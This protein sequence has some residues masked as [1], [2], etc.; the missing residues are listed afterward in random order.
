M[1]IIT[2]DGTAHDRQGRHACWSPAT[3]C[4][5]SPT[6]SATTR[7]ARRSASR[8]ATRIAD[9]GRRRPPSQRR[10]TRRAASRYSARARPRRRCSR[11][12]VE[13]RVVRHVGDDDARLA[14]QLLLDPERRLVVQ[15][16]V[17][18]VLGAYSGTI[19]VTTWSLVGPRDRA[20]VVEDRRDDLAV[21]R[22]D[23]GEP[24]A[25][26]RPRPTARVNSSALSPVTSTKTASIASARSVLAYWSARTSRRSMSLTSTITWLCRR[27]YDCQLRSA[28]SS[29]GS[30]SSR[31]HRVVAA[32]SP[33]G[34]TRP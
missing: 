7:S 3:S 14:E 12:V 16:R 30:A 2:A 31:A 20:H 27:L 25:A 9:G 24:D 28:S 33:T 32:A 10:A 13:A 23:D 22:L 18:G 11:L 6:A 8:P 19:T 5:C 21:R 15:H 17:G 29:A 1:A 26:S 4:C 34:S